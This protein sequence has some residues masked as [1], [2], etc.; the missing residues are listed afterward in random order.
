LKIKNEKGD[1][2]VFVKAP[3][4]KPTGR[5]FL[6]IPMQYKI[7]LYSGWSE[8]DGFW[9]EKNKR[10]SFQCFIAFQKIKITPDNTGV[11]FF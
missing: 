9:F 10:K 2:F 1:K 4:K 5:G 11:F 3:I 7:G 8:M 6:K